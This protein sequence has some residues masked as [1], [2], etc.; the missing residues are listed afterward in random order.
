LY[1]NQFWMRE[2][3]AL[4]NPTA[5]LKIGRWVDNAR[6]GVEL[7]KLGLAAPDIAKF[8]VK[9]ALIDPYGHEVVPAEKIRRHYQI[10]HYGFS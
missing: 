7:A 10:H 2:S 1:R 6:K 3:S 4:V 5:D 8:E 9:G